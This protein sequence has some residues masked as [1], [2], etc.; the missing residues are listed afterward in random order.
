MLS[1]NIVLKY[2]L[3]LNNFYKLKPQSMEQR[4]KFKKLQKNLLDS[5]NNHASKI[6]NNLLYEIHKITSE[7]LHKTTNSSSND[8][9][10]SVYLFSLR[11]SILIP[12][13]LYKKMNIDYNN[14]DYNIDNT[15]SSD[16]EPVKLEPIINENKRFNENPR[17]RLRNSF[18]NC[19]AWLLANNLVDLNENKDKN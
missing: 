12:F 7:L 3:G 1:S 11:H 17:E 13:I 14:S 8:D 2:N 4:K 5:K 9:C 18:N 10:V 16:L 19:S 6:D 15:I